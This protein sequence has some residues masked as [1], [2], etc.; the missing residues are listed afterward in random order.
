MLFVRW[1]IVQQPPEVV[2]VKS[3]F[4]WRYEDVRDARAA[5]YL[6]GKAS[7]RVWSQPEREAERSVPQGAKLKD[8][9]S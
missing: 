1:P 9:V 5:G 3:G 4:S 2:I 7:N 6:P 8:R